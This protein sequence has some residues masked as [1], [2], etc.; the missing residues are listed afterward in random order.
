MVSILDYGLGNINAFY[1]IYKMLDI[2][3]KI[4]KT[5]EDLKQAKN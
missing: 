1:N 3:V 5:S 2:G 4:A